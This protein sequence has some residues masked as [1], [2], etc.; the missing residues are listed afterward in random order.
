MAVPPPQLDCAGGTYSKGCAGGWSGTAINIASDKAAKSVRMGQ[1][2]AAG[3][4]DVGAVS[5]AM[6]LVLPEAHVLEGM[7]PVCMR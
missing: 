1:G 3:P 7:G 2:D 4:L 6:S 5:A